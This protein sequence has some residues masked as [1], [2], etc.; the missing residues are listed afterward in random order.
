MQILHDFLRDLM[1]PV[2]LWNTEMDLHTEGK[3]NV[4]NIATKLH[5]TIIAIAQFCL[6][7]IDRRHTHRNRRNT[8][9]TQ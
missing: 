6:C 9:Y 7:L 3:D 4:Q 5:S 2:L 1:E 8:C